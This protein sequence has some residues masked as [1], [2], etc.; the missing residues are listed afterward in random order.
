MTVFNTAGHKVS[1]AFLPEGDHLEPCSA[2]APDGAPEGGCCLGYY[3]AWQL[4]NCEG[5]PRLYSGFVPG[6]VQSLLHHLT[7]IL[8][9]SGCPWDY[10][11]FDIVLRGHSRPSS[12]RELAFPWSLEIA[13]SPVPGHGFLKANCIVHS[14]SSL[15]LRDFTTLGSVLHKVSLSQARNIRIGRSG[16]E[17]G[18]GNP[19]IFCHWQLSADTSDSEQS[20]IFLPT[21]Q[22]ITQIPL[23]VLIFPSFSHSSI[24]RWGLTCTSVAQ[25]CGP[26]FK[27]VDAWQFIFDAGFFC[28]IHA[29]HVHLMLLLFLVLIRTLFRPFPS[30]QES[31]WETLVLTFRRGFLMACFCHLPAL[32]PVN[33]IFRGLKM[34]NAI[35]AKTGSNVEVNPGLIDPD[36]I[37]C[38]RIPRLALG[39]GGF[40][41]DAC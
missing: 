18:D 27:E 21:G 37:I 36:T 38:T 15:S 31:V 8:L 1:L 9:S 30:P 7:L 26:A 24:F 6:P 20:A 29:F 23:P 5:E 17:A 4:S 2:R 41:L 11:G 35:S 19:C 22:D 10:T 16:A 33:R 14:V 40:W 34:A 25:G 32:H 12:S 39:V 13:S 28:I 3:E